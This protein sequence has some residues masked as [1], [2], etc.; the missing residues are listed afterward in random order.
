MATKLHALRDY[1]VTWCGKWR[2]QVIRN[3]WIQAEATCERCR[4]AMLFW[5]GKEV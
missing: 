4:K 5:V 3:T 2:S 1:R